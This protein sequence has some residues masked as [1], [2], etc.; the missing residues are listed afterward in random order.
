[1]E[2]SVH[3]KDPVL[4]WLNLMAK[5]NLIYVFLIYVAHGGFF[6]TFFWFQFQIIF[7]IFDH[8]PRLVI[9]E[10]TRLKQGG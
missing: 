8:I 4:Y 7:F 5:C 10:I 2:A 6:W 9:A 1:M 3:C